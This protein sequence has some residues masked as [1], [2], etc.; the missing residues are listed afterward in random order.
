MSGAKRTSGSDFGQPDGVLDEAQTSGLLAEAVV[1]LLN[2]ETPD[3]VYDAICDLIIGVCPDAVIVVDEI[4]PDAESFITRRVAGVDTTLLTRAT[5]LGGLDLIGRRWPVPASLLGRMPSGTLSRVLRGSTGLTPADVSLATAETLGKLLGIH[6]L[7]AVGITDGEHV[8]GNIAIITRA[9]GIAL[10]A[11]AIESFARH[12]YSTL[13]RISRANDLA[14]AAGQSRLLLDSMVEGLAVHEIIV[15]DNGAPCDYRFLEINAAFE[16]LTGLSASEVI[17]RTVL[18]VLPGT[19]PLWI[20]RF[21]TVASTGVPVRFESYSAELGK[22]FGIVAY[23]PQPGQ[24]AAVFSDITERVERERAAGRTQLLLRSSLK[25]QQGTILFSIDSQYRYLY[26]NEAHVDA[27]RQAYG[28]EIALG[29]SILDH[30]TAEEDRAIAKQNCD[31]ALGGESHSNIRE[32]GDAEVAA[33]ESFFNPIRDDE[34]VIIGATGMA[35]DVSARIQE[36]EIRR[37]SEERF[38]A[39]FT[40]APLG[41]Q[42]LDENGCFIDVNQAWLATLGYG[43]EEVIG[44]WFGDFLA[45]EYVDAFRERFP[46]F[47]DRGSIH[48]EFQMM[49]K[50]GSQHF[51]AFDGRIGLNSD[52]SFRQTHCI[53]ADITERKQVEDALRESEAQYRASIQ[54]AM[55]GFWL[56]GADG[57]LLTV[58]DAYCR[59]SGYT[60]EELLSMRVSQ[61]EVGDSPE[62]I[63]A[64]NERIVATGRDRF[65]STHRH[66]DGT[67]YDVEVSVSYRPICGGQ[68]S[69]FIRDITDR[70]KAERDLADSEDKFKYLFEHSMVAKSITSPGGELNV[71]AAFLDM[72]GYSR[73]ELADGTTWRR[74]T[75]PDDVD[76]TEDAVVEMLSGRRR[77]ARFETRYIRKDGS[78]LY[79]DVS[80]L[81]RR[82]AE[83]RPRYFMT[84][85]LDITE[86]KRAEDS[87]LRLNAELEERVWERTEKLTAMNEEL[88]IA[89]A[90]L[91]EA[92]RAKSDFL[93]S[94]SHEFRTPL[95][96]IIGFSDLLGRGMLGELEPEQLKRIS[97]IN[98]SGKHL[99]LLVDDVLDLSKIELGQS[100]AVFERCTV[101][102]LVSSALE[103]VR[104]LAAVKGI[105]IGA[106]IE[107]DVVS[108][109]SDPRF[110]SQILTNLL[111][112]AI[113]FTDAGSVSL[114]VL[115]GE[116]VVFEVIDTGRGIPAADIPRIM[117][118]F[119]QAESPLKTKHQG[120]G[121]GLAISSQLAQMLGATLTVESEVGRGS[122]FTLRI[123]RG[124]ESGTS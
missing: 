124:L 85:I 100:T 11:S 66:K 108:F 55:D 91:D 26:F 22:H 97:M 29:E 13:A 24:F 103:M 47:K 19:E 115:A 45:P 60:E 40:Q 76:R 9:P 7:F 109:E 98:A 104:P 8:L 73:E 48:S 77:S 123:P 1:T 118:R 121:L 70:K 62:E 122:T 59:M 80:T 36:Q 15:D 38:A 93:A 79:V 99:L 21:G 107:T 116:D 96:S 6:D 2:C 31:R 34:G 58:N 54:T 81:L 57:L 82:D 14:V 117:E 78:V 69:G 42:S 17:G 61:L 84:S 23:S 33:Y 12:C 27:M 89:N 51:I 65:E 94:M 87:F 3:G 119:Y 39:L 28:Q 110:V 112:N 46:V 37:R 71:N 53:I 74:F 92:T 18:E 88:R 67:L 35:R 101:A 95:N 41:Y 64:H 120:A 90:Q 63:A 102:P 10:P 106:F 105:E 111:G 32:Y 4:T 68:F 114:R 20:E 75:H 83:G 25:S 5:D 43:R 72:V 50:D 52:G 49:H 113:K 30:I 16:T 56:W 86:R 44:A